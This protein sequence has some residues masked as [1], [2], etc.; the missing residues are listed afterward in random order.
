MK[1]LLPPGWPRP[2]GYSNGVMAEGTSVYVAGMVGWNE[3]GEFAQGFV[4]QFEQ[5]LKNTVA[6]LG[7]AGATPADIVRMTWYIKDLD[8]YRDNLPAVGQR[9]Q[10]IIGKNF[11]AM[12]VVGVADLVARQAL[13]EIETTAVVPGSASLE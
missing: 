9:Y 3:S 5:V 13:L 4:A 2:A 1:H 10:E 12:A 8:S 7:E 11:P 6:V